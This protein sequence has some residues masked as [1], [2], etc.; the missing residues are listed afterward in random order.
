MLNQEAEAEIERLINW[1]VESQGDVDVYGIARAAMTWAYR[2]S[3]KACDS[4]GAL[5]GKTAIESRLG[6][7][8]SKP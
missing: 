2:D 8:D 5:D 1:G 3:I 7:L 4:V 6:P